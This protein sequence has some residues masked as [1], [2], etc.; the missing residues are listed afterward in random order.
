MKRECWKSMQ[1]QA[2]VVYSPGKDVHD[3]AMSKE[4]NLIFKLKNA[5]DSI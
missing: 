5:E 2:T 4:G 3:C 1:L